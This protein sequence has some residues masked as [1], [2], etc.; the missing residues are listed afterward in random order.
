M[1]AIPS[2]QTV[3][4]AF[5]EQ[6]VRKASMRAPIIPAS[7]G[8]DWPYKANEPKKDHLVAVV[9]RMFSLP[10][11]LSKIPRNSQSHSSLEMYHYCGEPLIKSTVYDH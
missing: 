3:N 11:R 8:T 5:T 4:I 9:K 1:P 2:A 10:A 6:R 7:R